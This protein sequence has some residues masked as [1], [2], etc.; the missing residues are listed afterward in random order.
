MPTWSNF[1][2]EYERSCLVNKAASTSNN[3]LSI[4]AS[5]ASPM[6]HSKLL[7]E[8]AEN[9][10]RDILQRVDSDRSLSLKHNIR[11]VLANVFNY[12]IERRFIMRIRASE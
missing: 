7:N 11:K 9:E 3:E 2:A 4:I 12:A 5:H 6:L 1:V 10:I 8:I